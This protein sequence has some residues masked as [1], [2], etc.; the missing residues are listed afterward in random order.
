MG[1]DPARNGMNPIFLKSGAKVRRKYDSC[2][3]FGKKLQFWKL[4]EFDK[5]QNEF[6]R[7]VVL[8][9]LVSKALAQKILLL[10][11]YVKINNVF[12]NTFKPPPY[13]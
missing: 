13:I 8:S 11:M 6:Y 7:F 2:K 5:K 9:F 1:A 4:D 10:I 3:H 12:K